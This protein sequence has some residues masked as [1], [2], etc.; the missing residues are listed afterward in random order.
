MRSEF[1]MQDYLEVVRQGITKK[2]EEVLRGKP[3]QLLSLFQKRAPKGE[4]VVLISGIACSKID[5]AD[6]LK[7]I[8]PP[9][10]P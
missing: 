2:F 6:A 9:I 10:I 1:P 5:N 4:F 8:D 3:D 7:R